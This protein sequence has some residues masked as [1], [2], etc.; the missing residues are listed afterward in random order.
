[1]HLLTFLFVLADALE[2]RAALEEARR[3]ATIPSWKRQL[4]DKKGDDAKRQ[5]RR[6]ETETETETETKFNA[7]GKWML[8][9]LFILNVI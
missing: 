3:L 4:M 2:E 6:E 7:F 5:G 1:M 9:L 8:L